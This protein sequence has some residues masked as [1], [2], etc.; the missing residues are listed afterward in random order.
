MPPECVDL[1]GDSD[2][3]CVERGRKR[4][5]TS[6]SSDV[7][8]VEGDAEATA[9]Q[10]KRQ[11]RAP[12]AADAEQDEDVV[13]ES[14]TGLVSARQAPIWACSRGG[15][16]C[17]ELR[18]APSPG[19]TARYG[20]CEAPVRQPRLQE[21]HQHDKQPALRRGEPAAVVL[22]PGD[23]L[24]AAAAVGL[25]PPSSQTTL[26]CG[27]MQSELP[28]YDH[29][30]LHACCSWLLLSV[31]SLD[32]CSA[33]ALCVTSRRRTASTGVTV[34]KAVV[35]GMHVRELLLCRCGVNTATTAATAAASRS[36]ACKSRRSHSYAA[37]C[38]STTNSNLSYYV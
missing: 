10:E 15:Q 5:R 18:F 19:G 22:L 28:Q 31:L 12:A 30:S 36:A 20:A 2:D 25:P 14:E 26:V 6:S 1:T 9:D 24:G 4:G 23:A 16:K 8:I 27:C 35:V 29:L 37:S 17:A 21:G 3:E 32:V 38:C 11:R 13:L 34:S 7:V 33:T